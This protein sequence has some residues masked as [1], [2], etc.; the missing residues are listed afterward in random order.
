ME[1]LHQGRPQV[2]TGPAYRRQHGPAQLLSDYRSGPHDLLRFGAEA[3]DVVPD[4]AFEHLG[5]LRQNLGR[6]VP[7]NSLLF[8][9]TSAPVSSMGKEPLFHE[10]RVTLGARSYRLDDTSACALP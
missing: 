5:D 3:V 1:A 7:N 9:D 4:E 6:L 10:K 8:V 2:V